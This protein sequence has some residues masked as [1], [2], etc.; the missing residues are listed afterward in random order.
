MAFSC[1]LKFGDAKLCLD[2]MKYQHLKKQNFIDNFIYLIQI[3]K[4]TKN[5]KL[6]H[7]TEVTTISSVSVHG[8]LNFPHGDLNIFR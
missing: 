3:G 7:K 1:Q 5:V 6:P 8:N 2:T 4:I